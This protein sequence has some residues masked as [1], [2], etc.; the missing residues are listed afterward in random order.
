MFLSQ[1]KSL[2]LFPSIHL[3]RFF[4]QIHMQKFELNHRILFETSRQNFEF[5]KNFCKHQNKFEETTRKKNQ[6]FFFDD[7]VSEDI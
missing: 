3:K 2:E 5:L 7:E 4:L 6:S 1:R